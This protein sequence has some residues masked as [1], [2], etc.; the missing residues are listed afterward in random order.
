MAPASVKPRY[1]FINGGRSCVGEE[2]AERG[3]GMSSGMAPP[4]SEQ[5]HQISGAEVVKA[6]KQGKLLALK[7]TPQITSTQTPCSDFSSKQ[8]VIRAQLPDHP[9][10]LPPTPACIAVV[11]LA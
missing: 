11:F 8:S 4:A 1:W 9:P 6:A 5:L 2:R 7:F 3:E 10:A